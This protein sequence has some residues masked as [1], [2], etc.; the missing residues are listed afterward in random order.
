MSRNRRVRDA[1]AASAAAVCVLG[2]ASAATGSTGAFCGPADQH[3][4]GAGTAALAGVERPVAAGRSG[5]SAGHDG[6]G[7]AVAQTADAPPEPTPEEEQEEPASETPRD[8]E[9]PP[10][11]PP[12]PSFEGSARPA[13]PDLTVTEERALISSGWE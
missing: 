10:A 1:L 4:C 9:T 7:A 13:G 6:A 2:L 12:E 3:R 11:P 5:A 8:A